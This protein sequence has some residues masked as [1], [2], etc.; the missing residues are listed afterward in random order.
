VDLGDHFR[1]GYLE[2]RESITGDQQ[3]YVDAYRVSFEV[4]IGVQGKGRINVDLATGAGPTAPVTTAEPANRLPL[5]RL[6]SHP[7][8]L[9]PLVDPETL[10]W[11]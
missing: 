3:P 10:R 2:H 6:T 4:Y 9:Y 7:Y 5:P 11:E 1:F 8:R